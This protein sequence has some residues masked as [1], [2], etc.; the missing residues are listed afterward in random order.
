MCVIYYVRIIWNQWHFIVN[1]YVVKKIII[2]NNITV[3]VAIEIIKCQIIHEFLQIGINFFNFFIY[4]STIENNFVFII[5]TAVY[6]IYIKLQFFFY[7]PVTNIMIYNWVFFCF[8][9]FVL[10]LAFRKIYAIGHCEL[11]IQCDRGS[12]VWGINRRI[13]SVLGWRCVATVDS[14]S[15]D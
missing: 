9:F 6:D 15:H 13:L 10:F 2:C 3:H 8:C 14:N 5:Y 7:F 4:S 11:V 12:S 1:K